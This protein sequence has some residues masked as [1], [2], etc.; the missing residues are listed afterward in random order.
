MMMMVQRK[1]YFI[2]LTICLTIF[3]ASCSKG[4]ESSTVEEVDLSQESKVI[5]AFGIIKAERSKD[6]II[7]FPSVVKE[8][9]VKEG[10]RV[11]LNEPLIN[12]D[13]SQ[14]QSQIQ[15]E[16]I[17][18]NI[19]KLEQQNAVKS[20]KAL[21]IE[22]KDSQINK[23]KNDLEFA[24]KLYEQAVKDFNSK[25]NLFR[26]GAISQ[27]TYNIFKKAMDETNNN[28]EDIEYELKTLEELNDRNQEQFQIN[29]ES[30]KNKT[31]I[32]NERIA[33]IENNI[34]SLEN[35][36]NKPYIKENQIISE[37]EN[38]IIYNINYSAGHITDASK[39]AFTISN[40]D[41][42]IVEANV[43]E[44]F[45]KDVKIGQSVTI[46]PVVDRTKE[47]EGNV[48][49]VSQ[50]AFN[51]SGETVVPV[52]ISISNTNSFLLPNYNV[53]V[54]IKLDK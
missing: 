36:L 12:L 23:L 28:V 7:D 10:Q 49:Y 13:L 54:F 16:K 41:S 22:N 26:D 32:Q 38:A 19:S 3:M 40:L 44:E 31:E 52:R 14:Y 39:I 43:A 50:M 45:I 4:Q 24:K 51:N 30:E 20:Y 2:L 46:V 42:L 17:K 25:E 33:Q 1:F 27:E 47:F 21:T 18:L 29:K 53:D 34:A 6:V 48:I 5:E 35:K 15:D 8:V 9:L 37:Y 11:V